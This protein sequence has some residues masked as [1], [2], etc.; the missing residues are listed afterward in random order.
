MEYTGVELDSGEGHGRSGG[1][2]R[3][4]SMRS[5]KVATGESVRGGDWLLHSGVVE[6][7]PGGAK[8][9]WRAR[10]VRRCDRARLPR[11]RGGA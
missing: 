11:Q 10:S 3:D 8:A 4:G 2:R 9:R 6:M 1:E 5:R 7:P